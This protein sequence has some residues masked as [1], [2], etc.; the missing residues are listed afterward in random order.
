MSRDKRTARS[1]IA[2]I[3]GYVFFATATPAAALAQQDP[4]DHKAHAEHAAKER[5]A[6]SETLAMQL[7]ELRAKVARL[8][9]ALLQNHQGQ[10]MTPT[11]AGQASAGAA[12]ASGDGMNM[13]GAASMKPMGGMGMMKGMG[14]NGMMKGMGMGGNG[15]MGGMGMGGMKQ[16]TSSAMPAMGG[17]ASADS[18]MSMDMGAMSGMRMEQK[19]R[20]SM[21]GKMGRGTELP[22]AAVISALPG[23]PGASHIYHIGASEHFLDYADALALSHEQQKQLNQVHEESQLEQNDFERRVEQA[24][25]EL[26]VLTSAGEPDA[27]AVAEKVQEIGRVQADMRLAFIRSVGKAAKLLTDEQRLRLVGEYSGEAG[28]SAIK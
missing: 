22:R 10:S 27:K 12:P 4:V 14:G 16:G 3:A 25:Q 20:M 1:W 19:K 24:E 15:M 6:E 17:S 23:F 7:A 28:A 26:W 21:M 18:G 13:G 9:S 2:A 8:E 11:D 5:T